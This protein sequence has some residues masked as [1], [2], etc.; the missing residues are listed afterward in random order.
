MGCRSCLAHLP[1]L[2]RGCVD[3]TCHRR[4]PSL[5]SCWVS[6]ILGSLGVFFFNTYVVQIVPRDLRCPPAVLE[7]I[8][9]ARNK[10]TL[11]LH[12]GLALE[13]HVQ[14]FGFGTV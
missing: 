14:H 5:F 2:K 7:Q 10:V 8:L 12:C 4:G 13:I 3:G 6:V 11:W 9:S 1:S